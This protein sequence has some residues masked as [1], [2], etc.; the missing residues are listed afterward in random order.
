MEPAAAF[1]AFAGGKVHLDVDDLSCAIIAIFGR[2]L[3]K[4]HVRALFAQH[5]PS[6]VCGVTLTAF[7]ELV[8]EH[9]RLFG[10]RDH[11]YR[12]FASL[13]EG[14]KGY[15]DL[16]TFQQV[17]ASTCRP[18][19]TRATEIFFEMDRSKTGAIIF[20]DFEAYLAGL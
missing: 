3:K 5:T 2:K 4:Q 14:D 9:R 16:A 20:S 11:A 19:A 8:A 18:A 6:G 12:M 7:E 10:E 1:A 15:L 17:C 13:D